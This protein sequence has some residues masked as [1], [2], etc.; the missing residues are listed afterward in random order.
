MHLLVSDLDGTLLGPSGKL[1]Q[2][3]YNTL[4]ALG[5]DR[6]IRVLATG[7]SLFSLRRVIQDDFP[8]DFLILS[9]G[10]GIMDWHTK[11]LLV[12]HTLDG[13]SLQKA[14][15]LLQ[16]SKVSFMVHEPLPENH[17]FVFHR[18]GQ[19]NSDFETRLSSYKGYGRPMVEIPE[20]AS[21]IVTI[22]PPDQHLPRDT[23]S[24]LKGFEIV[25]ATSP[26]DH[27]SVWYELHHSRSTKSNAAG[28]LAKRLGVG[29]EHTVAVGNDYNDLDLLHWAGQAFVVGNAPDELR[30]QFSVTKN[31]EAAPLTDVVRR[32][33]LL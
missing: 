30:Q 20:A 4:Q 6:V 1:H 29:I 33:G 23:M 11:K 9:G 3:D 14:I 26:I 12:Q 22:F 10:T 25:R 21:Q 27:A 24:R 28:W 32:C 7:R 16:Q 15:L 31:F 5:S 2:D 18:N 17:R 13:P 8:I 19:V